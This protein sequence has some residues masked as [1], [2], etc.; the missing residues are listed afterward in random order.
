MPSRSRGYVHHTVT[1]TSFPTCWDGRD[2]E[3]TTRYRH[4]ECW[5]KVTCSKC[6]RRK[7]RRPEV[8]RGVT[9]SG[10]P[11]V[12]EN[13]LPEPTC[14]GKRFRGD[15]GTQKPLRMPSPT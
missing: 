8:P 5:E 2:H 11:S 6:L 1:L 4:T 9:A 3:E 10:R 14:E 12:S 13:N 7:E 15:H